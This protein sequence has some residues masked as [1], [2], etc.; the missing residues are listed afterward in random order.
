MNNTITRI[1]KKVKREREARFATPCF[2]DL[3][4][5]KKQPYIP[6]PRGVLSADSVDLDTTRK[7]GYM[8]TFWFRKGKCSATR[9][10]D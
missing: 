8:A 9:P 7:A 3:K 1:V 6:R 10:K 4:P 5:E 2:H